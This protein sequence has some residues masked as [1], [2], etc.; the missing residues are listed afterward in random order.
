MSKKELISI[1]VVEDNH[2]AQKIARIVIE[3]LNCDFDIIDNGTHALQLFNE[4]RYDLVFVDLGLPD[5][6]GYTVATEIRQIEKRIS[7][8]PVI[9]VGLSVHTG[10][11]QKKQAI[12][13]GMNDYIIKPL[14]HEKCIEVLKKHLTYEYTDK[15]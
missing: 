6:D 14:T 3:S 10:E 1:L 8:K 7:L 5:K 2:I 11:S 13:S 9:I 15:G 4:N 12:D